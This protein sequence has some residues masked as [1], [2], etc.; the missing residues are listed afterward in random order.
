M[1]RMR[2]TIDTIPLFASDEEIGEAV[3]GWERRKEFRGL[4]ELHEPGVCPRSTRRGAAVTSRPSRRIS[5]AD[6]GW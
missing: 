2:L 5:I 4:A 1:A 6:T 3:L